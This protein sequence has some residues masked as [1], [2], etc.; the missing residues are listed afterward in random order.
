[1]ANQEIAL[2]FFMPLCTDKINQQGTI[3][4][5]FQL[6]QSSRDILK[7]LDRTENRIDAERCAAEYTAQRKVYPF[8]QLLVTNQGLRFVETIYDAARI[9][10]SDQTNGINFISNEIPD[11][12][13]TT[14]RAFRDYN[15]CFTNQ[16][17][18]LELAT[19]R[20]EQD[21]LKIA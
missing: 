13:L 4:D 18:K 16:T 10:C 12:T 6:W 2:E 9:T 21:L 17:P 8:D 7:C 14:Y 19:F 11:T 20:N 15:T 5:E 3:T 1:M